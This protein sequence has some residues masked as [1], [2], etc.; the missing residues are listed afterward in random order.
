MG[1]RSTSLELMV[2]FTNQLAMR[3]LEVLVPPEFM[4]FRRASFQTGTRMHIYQFFFEFGY[5]TG[6]G[7]GLGL[8]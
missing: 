6:V 1:P 4:I 2:L 7:T 3:D 8:G 5:R